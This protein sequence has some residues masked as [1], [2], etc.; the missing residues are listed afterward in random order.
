[1]GIGAED[2]KLGVLCALIT[3][4]LVKGPSCEDFNL[5]L[6]WGPDG[7]VAAGCVCAGGW[8]L[9]TV[10]LGRGCLL[11]GTAIDGGATG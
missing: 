2:G 8:V 10:A 5:S 11:L 3:G 7:T 4:I 9:G 6:T 1:M